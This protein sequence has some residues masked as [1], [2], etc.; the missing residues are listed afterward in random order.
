MNRC[1]CKQSRCLKLY[2]ECFASGIYCQDCNCQDCYNNKEHEQVR[3]EAVEATLERNPDAFRP[4]IQS[5]SP[6]MSVQDSLKH[7]KGCNCKRS[8]CLKRYCECFQANIF[9]SENC[10]CKDC[11]NY[12]GSASR[13]QLAQSPSSKLRSTLDVFSTPRKRTKG[14]K[15]GSKAGAAG[16]ASAA[17]GGSVEPHPSAG[18]P[19][20]AQVADPAAQVAAQ[21]APLVSPLVS[22]MLLSRSMLAGVVNDN[23]IKHL[24]TLLNMVAKDKADQHRKMRAEGGGDGGGG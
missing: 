5:M 20:T 6:G 19:T 7:N 1:N 11:K 17:N 18:E 4:K 15:R 21:A 16:A 8:F 10:R 9:C 13:L 22:Q 14:G 24:S 3:Q 2:C 12:E 23:V